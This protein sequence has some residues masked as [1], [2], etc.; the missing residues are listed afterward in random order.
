[1][2]IAA[3]ILNFLISPISAMIPAAIKSPMPRIIGLN[4]LLQRN[5]DEVCKLS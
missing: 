4:G 1:M 3:S 2:A 5:Q